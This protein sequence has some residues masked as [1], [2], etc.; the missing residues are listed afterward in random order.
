MFAPTV[1]LIALSAKF[2]QA[3]AS[4]ATQH[5]LTEPL[6]TLVFVLQLSLRIVRHRVKTAPTIAQL[7]LV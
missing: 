6:R 1:C 3:D 7:A 4:N 5:S 2:T